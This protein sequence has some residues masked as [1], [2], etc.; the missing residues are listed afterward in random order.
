[1]IRPA[2]KSELINNRHKKCTKIKRLKIISVGRCHW[3]KGYTFA[4]DAM[5]IL[6]QK[7]IYFHYTI[8]ASGKDHE[9]ILF[10]IH[11]LGLNDYISFINGLSHEDVIK[12]LSDYDLFLL[13]SLEE[14][15]SNSVLESMAQGV[16]VISTDC[17]GM[18]E[19]IN[20]NKNGFLIPGRDP[21][22][23][24]KKINYYLNMSSDKKDN[25][26]NNATLTIKNEYNYESQNN[27]FEK[28]YN[29]II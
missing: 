3:K 16:P 23:M 17:G 1:M 12:K 18:S 22:L 9:N 8:I 15:I 28:F 26:I 13:P 5:S 25:I 2:V 4:L 7:G 27:Q 19:V 10:Q 6:R 11:D 29:N 20:D 24:A 14:G 21:I